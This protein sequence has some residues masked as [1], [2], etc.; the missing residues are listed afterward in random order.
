MLDEG[1]KKLCL[2]PALLKHYSPCNRTFDPQP[3]FA[4]PREILRFGPVMI[5]CL[6]L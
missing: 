4:S 5:L 2:V 6:R 3:L 1:S